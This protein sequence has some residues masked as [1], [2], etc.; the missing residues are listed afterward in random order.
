[1]GNQVMHNDGADLRIFVSIKLVCPNIIATLSCDESVSSTSPMT[2]LEVEVGKKV[3]QDLDT[4]IL[5]GWA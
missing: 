3:R 4:S 5:R 1:M 2:L